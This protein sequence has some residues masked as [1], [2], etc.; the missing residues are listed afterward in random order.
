MTL[1]G[2][3]HSR[4]SVVRYNADGDMETLPSLNTPRF[5]HACGVYSN[6][7]GLTVRDTLHHSFLR[8]YRIKVTVLWVVL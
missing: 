6:N 5:H 8:H 3:A 1:T 4:T 7:D 2:G